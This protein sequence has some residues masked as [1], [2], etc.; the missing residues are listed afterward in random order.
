MKQIFFTFSL[1]AFSFCLFPASL[2]AAGADKIFEDIGHEKPEQWERWD[3]ETKHQYFRDLG[4]YPSKNGKYNGKTG[5]LTEYFSKRGLIQPE[6]WEKM[7]F[8]EKQ[9]FLLSENTVWEE[10]SIA[11]DPKI[12]RTEKK[13]DRAPEEKKDDS[14]VYSLVLGLGMLVIFLFFLFVRRKK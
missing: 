14:L 1:L 13:Q 3:R 7:T 10:P 12:Q 2:F 11:S 9:A 6:N 5:D 4:I 8:E